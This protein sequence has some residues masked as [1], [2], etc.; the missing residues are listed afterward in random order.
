MKSFPQGLIRPHVPKLTVVY[1]LMDCL[2]IAMGLW[3]SCWILNIPWDKHYHTLVVFFSWG[4]FNFSADQ[5]ELYR[6]WRSVPLTHEFPHVFKAWTWVMLFLMVLEYFYFALIP[7]PRT[8]VLSWFFYVPMFIFLWRFAFR[9]LL[10]IARNRGYNQRKLAIA[11]VSPVGIHVARDIVNSPWMGIHLT[12][13]YDDRAP[14][15][16]TSQLD[17]SMPFMGHIENMLQLAK[18]GEVDLV[19]ITL[20]MK[21]EERVSEIV[22]QLSDSTVSV[23]FFPDFFVFDLLHARWINV[24]GLPCISILESPHS[25][26]DGWLKRLEDLVLSGLILSVIAV[27]MLLIALFIKFSSKGPVIFRQRRYGL[28]GEEI[29]VWKFRTMTVCE[30]GTEVPQ[31]G[32]NDSRVTPLGQFLRRTSLDELPQFINVLQGRM[33]IVGPRP[34][35]VVHN[36]HYRTLIQG[37]MLRHK[38]LPGITGWAQIHGLRGKTETLDK[39]QKRVD[40]DLWYIRNWSLFLD[41]RIIFS[42]IFRAFRDENAY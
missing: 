21:A 8:L 14:E 25:G 39:M 5:H 19:Y 20:P 16:L 9:L 38:V 18:S 22:A 35:A 11:G 34:H 29:Y 33:S 15:R 7:F 24:A 41:L 1:R 36:E 42:T 27:P 4:L 28:D 23:Y 31:A 30:D 40:F 13:F 2:A 17:A 32:R 26:V 37:Y 6:P 10:R 3:W 12:G